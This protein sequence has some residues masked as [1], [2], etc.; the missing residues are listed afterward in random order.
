MKYM[1]QPLGMEDPQY[2]TFVCKLQRALYRLKQAPRALF[3]RFSTFI[4]KYGFFY[5]I[6]NPSL[7]IF[8]SDI[9]SLI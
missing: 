7:F 6:T 9:G 1:Q 3:D 2:P 8:Y 4:L 5:C